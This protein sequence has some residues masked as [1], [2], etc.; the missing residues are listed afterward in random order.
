MSKF[1]HLLD[2]IQENSVQI[3]IL[4]QVRDN[5]LPKLMVER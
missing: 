1:P 3:Q 5:L 2:K 4:T